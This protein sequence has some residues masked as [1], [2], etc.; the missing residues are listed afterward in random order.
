[1]PDYQNAVIYKIYC[2][3]KKIKEIYIGS[4]CGFIK[5]W[6]QHKTSCYYEKGPHYNS[7]LFRFIRDHGGIENWSIIKIMDYPCESNLEL[8]IQETMIIKLLKASL[9]SSTPY[10]SKAAKQKYNKDKKLDQTIKSNLKIHGKKYV[11][12]KDVARKYHQKRK[13]KLKIDKLYIET[14]RYDWEQSKIESDDINE[15]NRLCNL[16]DNVLK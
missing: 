13:I 10:L 12:N 14:N 16:V 1:M 5:R 8:R 7:K 15:F 2:N 3:D 4:T 11:Y 9:N 6:S